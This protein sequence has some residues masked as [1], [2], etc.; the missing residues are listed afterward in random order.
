C[1]NRRGHISSDLH[2]ALRESCDCY[3]YEAARRTGMERIAATA[4]SLGLG[5]AF[6]AG[7]APQSSGIVPTPQWKRRRSRTGWLIG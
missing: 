6:E 7:I 2:K 5:Q 1:W 4:M 3:F